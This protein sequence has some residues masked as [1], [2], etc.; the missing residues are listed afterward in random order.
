MLTRQ[1]AS[2]LSHLPRSS[3]LTSRISRAA[4]VWTGWN[5]RRNHL[6]QLFF[7]FG[8][9]L[10]CIHLC[11]NLADP[12]TPMLLV[13]WGEVLVIIS[14]HVNNDDFRCAPRHTPCGRC[15]R[16]RGHDEGRGV[17]RAGGGRL[18]AAAAVSSKHTRGTE[19]GGQGDG[20]T[21]ETTP[22]LVPTGAR[23]AQGT[24]RGGPA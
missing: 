5:R 16:T 11:E 14:L 3:L 1:L 10:G 22:C 23:G 13:V 8:L 9:L 21:S 2:D 19:S 18:A 12:L 6:C 24:L 20:D 15:P 17:V 7:T 4:N